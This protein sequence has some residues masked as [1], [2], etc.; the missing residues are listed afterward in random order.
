VDVAVCRRVERLCVA[1]VSRLVFDCTAKDIEE[2][3]CSAEVVVVAM[4]VQVEQDMLEVVVWNVD[5]RWIEAAVL[6]QA[7]LSPS[8]CRTS[9]C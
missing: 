6:E 5:E 1:F 9:C 4:Q 8:A 2:P 3:V 7:K